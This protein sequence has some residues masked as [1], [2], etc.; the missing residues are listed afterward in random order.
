MRVAGCSEQVTFKVGHN[1]GQLGFQPG[2]GALALIDTDHI[3]PQDFAHTWSSV[4]YYRPHPAKVA[5]GLELAQPRGL[6]IHMPAAHPLEFASHRCS[7]TSS[8]PLP[9]ACCAR[10]WASCSAATAARR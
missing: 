3:D 5:V 9:T 7:T 4:N 6:H 1:S 8:W 10:C 2:S